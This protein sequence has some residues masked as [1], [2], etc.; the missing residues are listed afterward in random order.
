[1]QAMVMTAFGGPEVLEM[2]DAA[3]PSPAPG[4]VLIEVSAVSVGRTLDVAARAGQLQFARIELPH[5]LGAEHAG[6]VVA[7]GDP[8][9]NGWIGKR[10]AVFPVIGCGHCPACKQGREEACR[11]LELIGIHRPGA[12]AQFSLAPASN[13]REVPTAVSDVEA[14]A[15]ALCGPAARNQLDLA[16]VGEGSTVL[17]I[18]AGSALG[19]MTALVAQKMRARVI[20]TSRS[21]WKR[22]QLEGLGVM[23]LDLESEEFVGQVSEIAEDGVDVIVDNIGSRLSWERVLSVLATGGTVASSGAFVGHEL[24]LD[25]RNLYTRNLCI[26]GVRTGNLCSVARFWD[27]VDDGLRPI[28]DR[29]FSLDDCASAHRYVEGDQ[30]LGRVVLTV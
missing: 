28:V 5:I 16:G 26:L 20:G 18:A 24:P 6:T 11:S 14:S 9:D 12:C 15:L 3:L 29:T 22:Q 23:A 27:M 19:S 17:V 30:N 2:A 10:V 4:E 1:M 21:E 8:S 13:L 25:L 7:A